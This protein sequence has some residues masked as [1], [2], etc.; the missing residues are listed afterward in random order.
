MPAFTYTRTIHFPDTDAAGVVFFVR[1]LAIAHEGYE[2]AL[3]SVGMPLATFFADH[4]VIV[5]IAKSEASYLRPLTC[6]DQVEVELTPSRLSEHSF[7]LDFVMWKLT[8]VRKRAAVIRTEHMCI[9][10]AS[11]H[12]LALPT[13]LANWVD[14]SA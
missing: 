12:R 9:A 7:A 14:A 6:G 5:P 11:H 13:P 8:P 2:E 4:G 10:S 1:Y 3:A